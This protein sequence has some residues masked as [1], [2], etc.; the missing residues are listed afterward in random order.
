LDNWDAFEDFSI[1]KVK[2]CFVIIL[3]LLLMI[4][5]IW[6]GRRQDLRNSLI[7]G[8]FIAG[9]K[10]IADTN[11]PEKKK[12]SKLSLTPSNESQ[13]GIDIETPKK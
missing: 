3:L 9:I 10:K 4:L 1:L 6:W 11:S 13:I 5:L 2:I 8:R 7:K 12:N